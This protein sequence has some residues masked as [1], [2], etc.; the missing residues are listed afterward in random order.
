MRFNASL[1]M[2]SKLVTAIIAL[3]SLVLIVIGI[4]NLQEDIQC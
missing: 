1:D 3:T 4:L 2:L